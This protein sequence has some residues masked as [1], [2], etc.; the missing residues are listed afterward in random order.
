[1]REQILN[2]DLYDAES[3]EYWQ[4]SEDPIALFK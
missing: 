2:D 4:N 1:M 3:N